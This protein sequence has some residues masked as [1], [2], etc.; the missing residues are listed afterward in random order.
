MDHLW[1]KW[2]GFQLDQAGVTAHV[3]YEPG[4]NVVVE[5][6]RMVARGDRMIAVV[7][8]NALRDSRC[9]GQWAA[10]LNL[11]SAGSARKLVPVLVE[12]CTPDA[13][14]NAVSPVRLYGLGGTEAASTLLTALGLRQSEEQEPPA[15]PDHQ[16][17]AASRTQRIEILL[18]SP[19]AAVAWRRVEVA[20]GPLPKLR[21][22]SDRV[23]NE[24]GQVSSARFE[25]GLYVRRDVERE[26]LAH[27]R[28]TDSQPLLVVG[29]PGV[30][31]SSLLWGLA[32]ELLHDGDREVFLMKA[33]WLRELALDGQPIVRRDVVAEAIQAAAAEGRASTVLVDTADLVVNDV[34]ALLELNGVVD[35]AEAA[36][37]SVLVTTRPSEAALLPAWDVVTLD[38]YSMAVEAGQSSEF[39]R[40]VATHCLVYNTTAHDA[41]DMA[42][43]LVSL[44]LREGPGGHLCSRPLTM[45]MLFE[46]YAP[47]ALPD[48]VDETALYQ[49]F[50]RDRVERDRRDWGSE[51]AANAGSDL[52]AIAT[53]MAE[54]MLEAGI[55]EAPLRAIS[56][57]ADVGPFT[58]EAGVDELV[59]RGVG[60]VTPVAGERVFRFFHQT[61]FEFVAAQALWRRDGPNALVRLTEHVHHRP[62]D[63]FLLAIY[64]QTWLCAWRDDAARDAVSDLAENLL[65]EFLRA[66]GPERWN[67]AETFPYTLQ[68]SV[69][70]VF[71]LAPRIP[72][73]CHRKFGE[74]LRQVELPLLRD[75]LKL[76]PAPSRHWTD[77]DITTLADCTERRDNAWIAVLSVLGRLAQRDP[78]LVVSAVQRLGLVKRVTS[79][80]FRA[81][82]LHTALT[83][84]LVRATPHEAEARGLLR[85]MCGDLPEIRWTTNVFRVVAAKADSASGIDFA[86]W[87]DDVVGAASWKSPAVKRALAE[88]H[89]R[90]V[91]SDAGQ[92]GDWSR[93]LDELKNLLVRLNGEQR[94]L[95]R[96]SARLAGLL[97]AFAQD[98]PLENADA[99]ATALWPIDS[100][101]VHGELRHGWLAGYTTR[102]PNAMTSIWTAWLVDGLPAARYPESGR[103][104]LWANTIRRTLENQ[105]VPLTAVAMIADSAVSQMTSPTQDESS[106]L[107][108]WL[109]EES[110]R[111][112]TMR[113]FAGGSPQA[114]RVIERALDEAAGPSGDEE[115]LLIAGPVAV[116]PVTDLDLLIDLLLHRRSSG[117]LVDLI[118]RPEFPAELIKARSTSILEL[119]VELREVSRA[120]PQQAAVILFDA[121]FRRGGVDLPEWTDL[122][123]WLERTELPQA[124][125]LLVELMGEGLRQHRYPPEEARPLLT[126]LLGRDS[127]ARRQLV[128]LISKWGTEEDADELLRL[129]FAKPVDVTTLA[130]VS[131]FVRS[132]RRVGPALSFHMALR[133]VA[134]F[135]VRLKRVKPQVRRSTAVRW[136][137][138]ITGLLRGTF[139]EEQLRLIEFLPEMEEQFASNVVLQ[140]EPWRY[141]D[142][143]TRLTVIVNRPHVG[144]Q[145][146]RNIGLVLSRTARTRGR[147]APW[148]RG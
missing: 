140:L 143:R 108:P 56:A 95:L 81:T 118:E 46:L 79:A 4:S 73:S 129:A 89:R 148:W 86:A 38:R 139:P 9:R 84:L 76:M 5:F 70:A 146:R 98:A 50:W 26:L 47:G 24:I 43:K 77:A 2:I 62:D 124:R 34:P 128:E 122:R 49:R 33:S 96:D 133:F 32:S 99:V 103:T 48:H 119:V 141:P 92:D 3:E 121:A 30:G 104:Q 72:P 82:N 78:R 17:E 105:S 131:N 37:A 123:P 68:R 110:L 100:L 65:D 112:L 64:E 101:A 39:E 69:L 12:R 35:I 94:P 88:L 107:G 85:L 25:A 20:S 14:L 21:F 23:R 13:L 45:R 115:G 10:V 117:R 8:E 6:D 31:K 55:P 19:P 111:R 41:Q 132:D 22:L 1:A 27:L 137:R 83:E 80:G 28:T 113:A 142:V 138:A 114:R 136:R 135:A 57:T 53:R 87:A 91:C 58:I 18:N 7:S 51:P 120:R 71:A 74:V 126:A 134:D 42:A 75:C 60:E 29:E 144:A 147:P 127:F 63:F 67:A 36:G 15:F 116:G 106:R 11:D 130:K 145:L 59:R 61:F 109:D 125:N 44:V 16:G 66:L 97:L 52:T 40:A 54:H 93:Y 90:Q 102:C